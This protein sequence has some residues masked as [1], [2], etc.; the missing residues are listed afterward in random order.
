MEAAPPRYSHSVIAA[1]RQLLTESDFDAVLARSREVDVLLFKHSTRCPISSAA[2]EEV[3]A[4]RN[5]RTGGV[6]E[7]AMVRVI[8]ER[9]VSQA[10]A[11]R[12]SVRHESPQ[13][14]LLRGGQPAGDL[15]HGAI[16]V[17]GLA[18]LVGRG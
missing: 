4:Y 2:F 9:P 16:T 17:D 3:A 13:V 1:D 8:E 10:I 12:L 6:P 5:R 11:H 18:E 7:I 15:S 14:I